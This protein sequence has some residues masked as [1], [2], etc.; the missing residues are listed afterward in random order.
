MNWMVYEGSR[1]ARL[2]RPLQWVAVLARNLG[3]GPERVH[4]VYE[5]D[6]LATAHYSPCVED[7]A[8]AAL[9]DEVVGWWYEGVRTDARWR[10]WILTAL[11][12]SCQGLPGDYVEFG[13]YRGGCAY[14]LLATDA[15]PAGS[16]LRLFDTFEGIPASKLTEREVAEGLAGHLAD[17]SVA[18]VAARL[19]RWKDRIRFC[20][21]DVFETLQREPAGEIAFVHMDLNASAP[22]A[23]A[24][25]WAWERMVP[26]AVVLFDDYGDAHFDDQRMLVDRF[27][28]ERSDTVIALPTGQAM[29]IK[30]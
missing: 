2:P 14:M 18:E 6:G 29:A 23:F 12:R 5:A 30:R 4:Y 25:D 16:T 28:S 22:T 26:G 17:T 1:I 11:A 13:T 8:F 24:L 3:A 7:T 9:Y 20:D 19:D 21:G 27:F 15:V 10:M